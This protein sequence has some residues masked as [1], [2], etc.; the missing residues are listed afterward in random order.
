MRTAAGNK[1]ATVTAKLSGG[2]SGKIGKPKGLKPQQGISA[3]PK[4]KT[5]PKV[6][7]NTFDAMKRRV[8]RTRFKDS[9]LNFDVSD[10]PRGYGY[11]GNKQIPAA[12]NRK[13]AF[14]IYRQQAGRPLNE[15]KTETVRAPFG[16]FSTVKNPAPAKA[17]PSSAPGRTKKAELLAREWRKQAKAS[18]RRKP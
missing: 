2:S 15:L 14:G 6:T 18:K 13:R 16:R 8:D 5:G 1:R 11:G 10:R 9:G 17:F 12:I 7:P 4:A 3:K